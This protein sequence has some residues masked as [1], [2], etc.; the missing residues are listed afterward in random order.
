MVS[1]VGLEP[2]TERCSRITQDLGPTSPKRSE[3][4]PRFRVLCAGCGYYSS[5]ADRAVRVDH[6]STG[7]GEEEDEEEAGA[8]SQGDDCDMSSSGDLQE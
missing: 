5:F 8:D 2:G 7:L 3:A 6:A 1:T 4:K